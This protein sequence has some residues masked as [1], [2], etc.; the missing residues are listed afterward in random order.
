MIDTLTNIDTQDYDEYNR[1]N[2]RRRRRKQRR[3][4]KRR[5]PPVKYGNLGFPIKVKFPTKKHPKI[6]KGAPNKAIK[7]PPIKP[8]PIKNT[9]VIKPK[10]QASNPKP[11][12]I[13]IKRGGKAVNQ[14]VSIDELVAKTNSKTQIKDKVIPANTKA[15]KQA[16]TSQA[17]SSDDVKKTGAASD[18]KV[19]KIIKVVAGI[20][21]MG[22]TGY[23]I[24]RIVKL[25]KQKQAQLKK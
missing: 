9:G 17:S 8:N 7:F 21:L 3:R 23:I 4:I 15:V 5:R 24:Y 22:V 13:W 10:I 18:S 1:R 2:F 20:G 12:P 16:S 11:K 19:G 6:V 14:K 25:Q